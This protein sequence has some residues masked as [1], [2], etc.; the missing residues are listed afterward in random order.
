[1]DRKTLLWAMMTVISGLFLLGRFVVVGNGSQYVKAVTTEVTTSPDEPSV[2][3]TEY[4]KVP[5]SEHNDPNV[6]LS[7]P[8]TI[9]IWV[10]ALCTLGIFSF[11]IGDSPLY[12]LVE[13]VF[14]GVSAAYAMVVG[15]WSELIPNLFGKLMPQLMRT[16]LIPSLT[17]ETRPD[18]W[19]LVPLVLSVMMLWRLSP[20]GG[21]I[22]RWPLAFF[23]GATA[24][25]RLVST[26]EADFVQQIHN[27]ILPLAVY[28]TDGSVDVWTTL[29]NSIIVFGTL[30][31]LVY[32]FFSVEHKGAVGAVARGGVWLLMITFGASF[33]YTVMGRIALL[34]DRLD[35]LLNNWL[36]LIDP[37]GT[38]AGL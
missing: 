16:T 15:F 25:I 12:K 17:E 11:L 4:V 10:A 34:A 35:F 9:G 1:M 38:R 24:G 7:L 20:K 33:G 6:S 2:T 23:I 36:W 19:Y 37:A 14:V 27:T 32:F 8:R 22:S 5:A 31:G 28:F 26:L 29:K 18:Y 21:W 30:M 3:L 13:S